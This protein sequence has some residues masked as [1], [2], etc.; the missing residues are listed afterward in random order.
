M[1]E[2]DDDIV[3]IATAT[4]SVQAHIWQQAL[5]DE[6]IKSQV[7]GD[8]LDA[9][10]GDIPGLSAEVWVLRNDAERAMEIIDNPA[11]ESESASAADE[12]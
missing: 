1:F 8:M 6:G 5:D 11:P 12:E 7:V 9:G 3:C 10:I 4:N 2:Q